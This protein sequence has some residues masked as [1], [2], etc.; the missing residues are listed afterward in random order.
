[1]DLGLL[2]VYGRLAGVNWVWAVLLTLYHAVVSIALPILLVE[3]LYPERRDEPWLSRRGMRGVGFLLAADVLF[4]NI[5]LTPY[6]PPF[7]PFMLALIATAVIV[8]V[9]HEQPTRWAPREVAP[10]W[11]PLRLLLTG[12]L[13]IAAL[14]VG[15]W[16]LPALNVPAF[17]TIVFMVL[18]ALGMWRLVRWASGEGAWDDRGR[19]ALASG[20]LGFFILLAFAAEGD[21]TRPDNPAG[22]GLVG[23][24]TA[25]GLAVFYLL[26]RRRVILDNAPGQPEA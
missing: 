12:F 7:A 4:G 2:G 18:A 24:A 17:L 6:R 13:G 21:P 19:L 26:V 15:G 25:G 1:M 11:S 9:A 16:A 22:M 14:F 20:A 10:R 3:I 5:V 23:L 8:W